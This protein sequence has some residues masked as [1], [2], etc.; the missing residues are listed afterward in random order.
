MHT[1]SRSIDILVRKLSEYSERFSSLHRSCGCSRLFSSA[2][3]APKLEAEA[4]SVHAT[5]W[6]LL[7]ASQP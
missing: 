3:N 6:T 4:H 5:L 7:G 2:S 1:L